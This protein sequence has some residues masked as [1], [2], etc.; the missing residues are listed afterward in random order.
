MTY[1]LTETVNHH[2][3]GL[4][5]LGGVKDMARGGN[6]QAL[7]DPGSLVQA[8][9]I[10]LTACRR[11]AA[12]EFLGP[13]FA[14]NRID[15]VDR[16]TRPWSTFVTASAASVQPEPNATTVQVL[17]AGQLTGTYTVNTDGAGTMP[18]APVHYTQKHTGNGI[19]SWQ[20]H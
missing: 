17:T 18:G 3:F 19:S 2:Q 13:L 11:I 7:H 4:R 1:G 15:E 5:S 14:K 6:A 20:P 8:Q 12:I 10:H 16:L 9:N